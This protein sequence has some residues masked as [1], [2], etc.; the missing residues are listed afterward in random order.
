MNAGDLGGIQLDVAA[1]GLA[2]GDGGAIDGPM[3]L[4]G[5]AVLHQQRRLGF[6]HPNAGFPLH[7]EKY[8]ALDVVA[9]FLRII[10]AYPLRRAGAIPPGDNKE[11]G[12]SGGAA[13]FRQSCGLYPAPYN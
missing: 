11:G 4:G 1:A 2:E 9:G 5:I 3:F 8:T 6:V 12:N 13:L 10:I 7:D